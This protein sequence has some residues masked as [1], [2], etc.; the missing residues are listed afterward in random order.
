MKKLAILFLLTALVFSAFALEG[1]GDFTAG[2]AIEASD[3]NVDETKSTAI[4]PNLSFSRELIP[5]LKLT[6]GLNSY[7]Q[8]IWDGDTTIGI[9]L[10]ENTSGAKINLNKLDVR[11]DSKIWFNT[12]EL[13]SGSNQT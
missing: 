4:T 9:P 7:L 6:A 8:G 3:I 1:V 11:F 5:A 2:L 12:P 10:M 13:C